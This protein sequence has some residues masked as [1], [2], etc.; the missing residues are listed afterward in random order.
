MAEAD[1]EDGSKKRVV[2]N[3]VVVN[4][5]W[6]LLCYPP[7]PP[8]IDSSG[9]RPVSRY[10]HGLLH[11]NVGKP[12]EA[13]LKSFPAGNDREIFAAACEPSLLTRVM[14]AINVLGER[15]KALPGG[16]TKNRRLGK[17]FMNKLEDAAHDVERGDDFR[18]ESRKR[19]LSE[20]LSVGS[21]TNYQPD[22]WFEQFVIEC[23]DQRFCEE[24]NRL[25]IKDARIYTSAPVRGPS[26]VL[27]LI[28]MLKN[29]VNE[30][31]KS[32]WRQLHLVREVDFI[33]NPRRLDLVEKV[34]QEI[35]YPQCGGAIVV[36]AEQCADGLTAFG[37]ALV[38]RLSG[39]KGREDPL[40]LPIQRH[41]PY[42]QQQ[43][44]ALDDD[45]VS[46]E[47]DSDE[48]SGANDTDLRNAEDRN[49]GEG[50]EGAANESA[51]NGAAEDGNPVPSINGAYRTLNTL[52]ILRW[53]RYYVSDRKTS[54]E[55]DDAAD[56][57]AII[58]QMQVALADPTTLPKTV[59]LD[60]V[61]IP[62]DE[63]IADDTADGRRLRRA[64]ADDILGTM[65]ENLMR[66]PL[67]GLYDPKD[68]KAD[69][70]DPIDLQQFAR[71]RFVILAS[72]QPS[73][74]ARCP[75]LVP[76]GRPS[77][78]AILSE[79]LPTWTVQETNLPP[80][81]RTVDR[82]IAEQI[83][84]AQN[85]VGVGI[86]AL[87]EKY[88]SLALIESDSV[89]AILHAL[90]CVRNHLGTQGREDGKW[91]IRAFTRE[92][93]TQPPVEILDG[94]LDGFLKELYAE[95]A[96]HPWLQ[97]LIILSMVP[98]GLRR[99]TLRRFVLRSETV[100][101]GGP[102]PRLR[103][104]LFA[105]GDHPQAGLD[106]ALKI[107][108]PILSATR[109]D[110][111]ELFDSEP[112]PL[113]LGPDRY[114]NNWSKDPGT[115]IDIALPD[116]KY[117][118]RN[119]ANRFLAEFSNGPSRFN[120]DESWYVIHRLL[121]EDAL[122]QMTTA[123]RHNGA[124]TGRTI[125]GWRRMF[126]VLYHGLLSL[127]FSKPPST[128][129]EEL[130]VKCP[131][132]FSPH[133][134]RKYYEWLRSFAYRKI[135]EAPPSYRLSRQFG[136]D[137]LRAE[138]AALFQAPW[139]LL[140]ESLTTKDY[141]DKKSG[142]RIPGRYPDPLI[143]D[144]KYEVGRA[145][146]L[147]G[148]IT[149]AE[150]EFADADHDKWS[151]AGTSRE[152]L[153]A[154][155][156]DRLPILKRRLDIA[157]L[158]VRDQPLAPKRTDDLAAITDLLRRAATQREAHD[159]GVMETL[160]LLLGDSWPLVQDKIDAAAAIFC[161][162]TTEVGYFKESGDPVADPME[163]AVAAIV[164]RKLETEARSRIGDLMFRIGEHE[165]LAGWLAGAQDL[166]VAWDPGV[167]LRA[168]L[169]PARL[170]A[171][172]GTQMAHY[173]RAYAWCRLGEELRLHTFNE[174]PESDQF[175]AS[176]H[177]TRVM[178]RS[179]LL[180]ERE[181][182]RDAERR[183]DEPQGHAREG[184][185]GRKARHHADTLA[186][187][188]HTYDKERS[189]MLI[190]EATMLRM[191]SSDRKD[192]GYA[193]RYLA[194]ADSIMMGMA[195]DN[196]LRLSLLLERAKVNRKLALATIAHDPTRAERYFEASLC[197][198]DMI[199][200]VDLGAC[201]LW[202]VISRLQKQRSDQDRTKMVH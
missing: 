73:W 13:F 167:L 138:F 36:H 140:P 174:Q 146:W 119:N 111:F 23:I 5:I 19:L 181:A 201:E 17:E 25:P 38:R 93:R 92:T 147:S 176:A 179:A 118:I 190:L 49:D 88:P 109:N 105:D 12:P 121:A 149:A 180:L 81:K 99:D 26:A 76:G 168:N 30:T 189:A 101:G 96:G 145:E 148:R 1:R 108:S 200:Q 103:E 41:R 18:E 156:K 155:A 122:Q 78:D 86:E 22:P 117:L 40:L 164:D 104:L 113:E 166:L 169:T 129:L 142:L 65:I 139:Q 183:K 56:L 71:N 175:N 188:M 37:C 68:A 191:L 197:D 8:I 47:G 82:A 57:G 154:Y 74:V 194:R 55:I 24:P 98:D 165:M 79:S 100:D 141:K 134:S 89:L 97:L 199:E 187:Y 4:Q 132:L 116:V 158:R 42:P 90:C 63:K 184:Y 133:E 10:P 20:H 112:H 21:A 3:N 95:P 64:I 14:V 163:H 27:Q 16:D 151:R 172:K 114:D 123:L 48:A 178:V 186:R 171:L 51:G 120:A 54:D 125:R 53:L 182:R 159:L 137:R 161:R 136:Q 110:S 127:P 170:K 130:T 60:G 29:G 106:T 135:L 202:T 15:M 58:Q 9:R 66:P 6:N 144:T 153:L 39:I 11:E 31:T 131:D 46:S 59:I 34:A 192:L 75:R 193:A 80:E 177:A 195:R 69:P 126:S 67:A 32:P 61:N 62:E 35:L 43:A 2:N 128:T 196:R 162:L 87:W 152:A 124:P 50:S 143:Q 107:L 45:K 198:I 33:P 160:F 157:M 115:S 83:L 70:P 91:I 72:S 102:L 44:V 185:F 28:D 85:L 77:R 150:Q 84:K 94:I 173:Y 7:Q 52:E